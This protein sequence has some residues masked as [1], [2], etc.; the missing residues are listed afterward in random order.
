MIGLGLIRVEKEEEIQRYQFHRLIAGAK[1]VTLIYQQKD[2]SER[3]RFIEELIW[4]RQKREQRFE[5]MPIPLAHFRVEVLPKRLAIQKTPGIIKYLQNIQYSASSVNTYM[6]C[7]LRFYYR[8]VLGLNEQEDLLDE[9]ENVDVGRFIHEL[10]EK[11]Y[12]PFIG[13][14]PVFDESFEKGL[15]HLLDKNF[16]EVFEKK[17]AADAF[18]VKEVVTFRMQGF[19]E[20]EREQD[21]KEIVCLEKIFQ[22]SIP[23]HNASYNF[24]AIVDRID[25]L[26]DDS[27]LIL[28]YKTG[29]LD[30]V[31]KE[32]GKIRDAGYSREALKTSMRSF[33]L[34][35]YLYFVSREGEFKTTSVD[36]ALYSMRDY[37]QHHLLERK[38]QTQDAAEVLEVSREALGAMVKEMHDPAV[39]FKADQDDARYCAACPFF[40]LCR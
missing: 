12:A 30:H 1:N 23:L 36:A 25:R 26:A 13:K 5:V 11:T 28:D 8:Y 40:Y 20:N 37:K 15:F 38:K 18:L 27:L 33:Q 14:A 34:P 35:L 16:T 2:E 6:H 21:I 39:P 17:M 19:L 7:P 10:L 4:E 9:A 3:S 32:A 22:G 24:I 31:P 29:A